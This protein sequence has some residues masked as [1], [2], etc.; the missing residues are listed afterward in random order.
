MPA[1]HVVDRDAGIVHLTLRGV[2]TLAEMVATVQAVMDDLEPGRRYDVLSDHRALEEPA[3]RDQL[4]QLTEFL[5]SRGTPFH[6]RRWAVIVG[7]PA[8]F[9]VI[10]MLS[11]HLESAPIHAMP[12]YDAAEARAWLAEPRTAPVA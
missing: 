2:L 10:R 12:F 6:G 7:S 8:S 5:G 9:G 4:L 11:V 3:T 1:T